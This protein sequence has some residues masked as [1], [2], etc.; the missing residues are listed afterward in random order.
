V[1]GPTRWT[2]YVE[3]GALRDPVAYPA[4]YAAID[5][6]NP[7]PFYRNTCA[8]V[9][10]AQGR[11]TQDRV[12]SFAVL[13][14]PIQSP[15]A[16]GYRQQYGLA[17]SGGSAS[18]QYRVSAEVESEDGV[19]KMP[20]A[21][22]DSLTAAGIPVSPDELRPNG[23]DRI[24]IRSNFRAQLSEVTDL[25]I[26]AGYV[27]SDLRRPDN[28]A[29]QLGIFFGG[30]LGSSSPDIRNGWGAPLPAESMRT[31]TWQS[32]NRWTA[33]ATLGS[34][35]FSFLTTHA[36][37]GLD[38]GL[39]HDHW[40][41]RIF[42]TQ[43]IRQ[44]NRSQ[45]VQSTVDLG[46]TAELDLTP[47]VTSRT[48][49][50]AQYLR[51]LVTRHRARGEDFPA[52]CASVG[53]AAEQ[54][55]SELTDESV[56][57]GFFAE[58]Q[59]GLNDRLFL[60]G[61][62]RADDNSAFGRDFDIAIYPKVQL[63]W[64]VSEEDFFPA[65]DV[66]DE[67]RLRGAWG[68]SGRAPNSLESV[69][70][71]QGITAT[72]PRGPDFEDVSG[73]TVGELGNPA[74]EPERS[75]EFETGFDA[76]LLSGR[77]GFE[78]TWYRKRTEDALVNEPLPAS[79]GAG[80]SRFV[81]VGRVKNDG[82]EASLRAALLQTTDWSVDLSVNASS[83]DN[84]LLEL[85]DRVES[86]GAEF[87][88]VEGFPLGG[89][90]S[91]PLLSFDDADGNGF[92]TP[93]EI[94]VGDTAE[95]LGTPYPTR[96]A[97]LGAAVT[98]REL[99][100]L[101]ALLDVRAGGIQGNG[102]EGIRCAFFVCRAMFDRGAP[103]E[104]QAKAMAFVFH[105]SATQAVYVESSDFARLREASVTV[106]LPGAWASRMG[107]SRATVSL[108]GRNLITWT[109]YSGLDPE[110]NWNGGTNFGSID[111]FSQA[112]PRIFSVRLNVTF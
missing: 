56:T 46:A 104:E 111:L 13:E 23:L 72:I 73:I 88:H 84:E 107:A 83:N 14:D 29:S 59:L 9:F 21:V 48:S 44:S 55:A 51:D 11:C 65:W 1:P 28:D 36:T 58:H 95:F 57:L 3:M 63:S 61:G 39:V 49:V 112:P 86:I 68:A 16:T 7:V 42:N 79:L 78:L 69:R 64:L 67:L 76:S 70:Y 4:S 24:S 35:P 32:L 109:D 60:S 6:D 62:I 81:N 94:V 18:F 25:S 47:R 45:L 19:W 40:T 27:S 15:F 12:R 41:D 5:E 99:V 82:F 2:A 54:S 71:Y 38:Y 96:Q 43:G 101:D 98:W 74:L 30:L 105:P 8:L 90:W 22:V 87:R 75:R 102:T 52:G 37:A 110:S 17:V 103:L 89:A 108:S 85:G 50:G 31:L 100:R 93:N 53:C 97:T 66:L 20:G 92:L 33:G 26:T 91:P 80:P 77:L 34:R 10:E 106:F